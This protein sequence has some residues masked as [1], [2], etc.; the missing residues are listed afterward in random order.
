[1]NDITMSEIAADVAQLNFMRKDPAYL[2]LALSGEV[3]E[4]NNLI[5]K[6]L[7]ESHGF[8]ENKTEEISTEIPDILFYLV[9]IANERNLDFAKMWHAKMNH[10]ELKYGRSIV[11]RPYICNCKTCFGLRVANSEYEQVLGG[12]FITKRRT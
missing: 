1:M 3:G 6:E 8:G 11:A 9:A 5:K 12:G 7:R 10:N 2:G 4:L